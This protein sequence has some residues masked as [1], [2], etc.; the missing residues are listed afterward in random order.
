[1][2]S[3]LFILWLLTVLVV[4]VIAIYKGRNGYLW[5]AAAVF[6][7]PLALLAVLLVPEVPKDAR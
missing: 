4:A 5:S 7:W 2:A 3:F 1:M 6:F